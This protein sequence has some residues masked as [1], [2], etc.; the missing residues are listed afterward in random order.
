MGTSDS[1]MDGAEN[2]EHRINGL[3]MT[4]GWLQ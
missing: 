4:R 1:E 3:Q 2:N